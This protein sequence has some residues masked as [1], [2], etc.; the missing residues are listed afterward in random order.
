MP[1]GADILDEKDPARRIENLKK[2]IAD[3]PPTEILVLSILAIVSEDDNVRRVALERLDE[4]NAAEGTTSARVATLIKSWRSEGMIM[5]WPEPM[6]DVQA[7]RASSIERAHYL[8]VPLATANAIDPDAV[9]R[10]QVRREPERQEPAKV[11]FAS[12]LPAAERRPWWKF[13]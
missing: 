8:R 10:P 9:L 5:T 4:R 7:A 2:L 3:R 1:Y 6:T 13:W 11:A 12:V